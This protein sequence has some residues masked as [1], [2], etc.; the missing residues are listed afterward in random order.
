MTLVSVVIPVYNCA[1]YLHQCLDS[2]LNQSLQDIE[3]I[4]VDDGSTDNSLQILNEYKEKD[5]RVQV[6]N[7][8]NA[9]Q[10]AARNN[11]LQYV[12]GK[13]VI[14]VDSDDWLE[15]DA[16]SLLYN[17]MEKDGSEIVLFN[18]YEVAVNG[19]KNVYKANEAYF[20]RCGENVFSPL[21]V[22]DIIY[23]TTARPF[24][25]Y[26]HESM[27][28][29]GY[30]YALHKH[31]EDHVPFFCFFANVDKMSVLNEC[32]YNYRL[33]DNSSTRTVERCIDAFYEDFLLC[34]RELKKTKYGELFFEQFLLRKIRNFFWHYKYIKP[35]AKKDFY[36]VMQ[37]TFKYIHKNIGDDKLSSSEYFD[38]YKKILSMP[39]W[40]FEVNKKLIST[41][42][43]LKQE[44]F[45]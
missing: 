28:K 21:Q 26:R 7:Q 6:L 41:M 44:Y 2:I 25:I 17:K 13:Y 22:K 9:G 30:K 14:F 20:L 42:R 36:K 34:E 39:H 45:W 40:L 15:P 32:V 24:K 10:G 1:E 43:V 23:N 11:A 37:K 27:K 4:C 3:I 35:T 33:R 29:Y 12:R 5:L 38:S 18:A 16:L 19:N 31:L 8:K